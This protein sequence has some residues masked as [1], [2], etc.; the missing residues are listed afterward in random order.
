MI[1]RTNYARHQLATHHRLVASYAIS[2][3]VVAA[4]FAGSVFL[5]LLW[6]SHA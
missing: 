4:L 1:S 2:S 6:A 5:V 3:M